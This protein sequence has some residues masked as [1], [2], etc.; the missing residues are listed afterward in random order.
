[1]LLD[2]VFAGIISNVP[3][4]A[5]KALQASDAQLQSPVAMTSAGLF[6]SVIT[7]A[8]MA[9]RRKLPFMLVPGFAGAMCML[10][11][12][13]MRQP[14]WF[15][16]AA[17]IVSIFD[18]ALRPAIPSVVRIVYPGHCQSHVAG[19]LRQYASVVFPTSVLFFA[20]LL[21]ASGSHIRAMITFR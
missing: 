12:A 9:R 21:T 2:A 6:A 10:I 15:L 1:V 3:L 8:V 4:M 17:G 18:F 16:I 11:M 5:V 7:G 20:L 14:L 13:W 19:T